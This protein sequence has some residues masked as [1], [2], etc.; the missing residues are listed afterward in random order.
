MRLSAWE[1]G[2]WSFLMSSVHGAGLMLVPV[3]AHHSPLPAGASALVALAASALHTAA[4][5][6]TAGAVALLVVGLLGLTVLRSAW[7]NVDRVWAIALIAAG[8]VTIVSTW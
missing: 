1:L 8:A 5:L 2:T 3:L 6:V 7:L 4:M